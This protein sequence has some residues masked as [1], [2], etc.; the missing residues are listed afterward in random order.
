MKRQIAM[1]TVVALVAIAGLIQLTHEI[2]L[3]NIPPDCSATVCT[4]GCPDRHHACNPTT[5]CKCPY[6]PDGQNC[7]DYCQGV[8]FQ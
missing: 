5:A 1:L 8:C 3:A 4:C 2:A 6:N 7:E